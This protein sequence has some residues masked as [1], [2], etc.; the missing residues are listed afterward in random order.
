[1]LW[2]VVSIAPHL[3]VADQAIE[4]E[5]SATLLDKR[6]VVQRLSG[7]LQVDITKRHSL[8]GWIPPLIPPL[9]LDQSLKKAVEGM[10]T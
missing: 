8:L 10:K 9:T 4:F 6:A 3:A 5:L 7:S 1:M 2:S